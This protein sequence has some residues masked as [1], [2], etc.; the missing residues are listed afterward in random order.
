[1][2]SEYLFRLIPKNIT[3]YMMSKGLS[4]AFGDGFD[5]LNIWPVDESPGAAYNK[6]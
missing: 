5:F 4:A 2:N 3:L 6:S 1:V